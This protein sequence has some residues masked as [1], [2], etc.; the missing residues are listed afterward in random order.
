MANNCDFALAQNIAPDCD[1]P[2]VRGIE[3]D[4]LIMNRKDVDF[5]SCVKDSTNAAIIKTFVLKSGCK[6]YDI[7]QLGATPF[8]GTQSAFT[9]G[10]Y[11]NKFTHDVQFLVPDHSPDVCKNIIDNLANGEFVVIL[12]NKHKGTDGKAKYQVYGYEGGLRQTEGTRD[13]YSEETDGGHL[14]KLQ[15]IAPSS[16]IF[17]YDTDETT[18]D[19]AIASLKTP[20]P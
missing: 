8:T 19:A 10:T 1:N 5:A 18:T 14:V 13:P 11:R 12:F 16:G 17:I 3:A 9:A 20:Q 15:E 6:A 4:G 7:Q 2:Q